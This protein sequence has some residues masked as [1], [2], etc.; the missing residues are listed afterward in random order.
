MENFDQYKISILNDI[1]RLNENLT[2]LQEALMSLT[3]VI[4]NLKANDKTR[5]AIYGATGGAI[6]AILTGL[7]VRA[8]WGGLK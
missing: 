8:L 4:E 2:K 7:I 3:L 6:T 1:K 5:S